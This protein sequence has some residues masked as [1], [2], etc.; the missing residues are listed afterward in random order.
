[1]LVLTS[2]IDMTEHNELRRS[3]QELAHVARIA[4]MGELAGSLAHELNRP[5]T[6]ILSNAQAAQRYIS[7]DA[8]NL[9]DM[10][11]LLTDL[12][13]DS[14]RAAEIIRR[15]RALVN[16]ASSNPRASTLEV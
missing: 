13:S 2:I 5:L 14:N 11:E 9:A 1:M 8:L 16:G 12:A 3:R 7:A 10:A 15:M 4:S 6:A